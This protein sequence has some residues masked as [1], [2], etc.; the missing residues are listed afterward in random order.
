MCVDDGNADTCLHPA[1]Q[2]NGGADAPRRENDTPLRV[3]PHADGRVAAAPDVLVSE[4]I[5]DVRSS[6]SSTAPASNPPSA[7]DLDAAMEY[8]VDKLQPI[9]GNVVHNNGAGHLI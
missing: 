7:S 6:D 4:I 5:I 8:L 1:T 9:V 2:D 3:W